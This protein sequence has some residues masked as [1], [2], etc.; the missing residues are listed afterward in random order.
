LSL[1]E[2]KRQNKIEKEAESLSQLG[3][4]F[5]ETTKIDSA[6]FY[7]NL[8][9]D[10]VNKNNYLRILADNYLILSKIEKYRGFKTSA[11]DFFEKYANIRDS[12]F[13]I[14]KFGDI[15]QLQHSYEFS[16]T[17]QQIEQLVA[18]QKD[19]EHTIYYQR[20]IQLIMLLVLIIISSLLLFIYSQKRNLSKAYSVLVD[21]N[22]E[23]IELQKKI[24]ESVREI[25]KL[26][27]EKHKNI[28]LSEESQKELLD[29]I[30][31][32]MENTS[33][34]CN[35]EFTLEKLTN[36]I[37]SN[38]KYVSF[39][40]N[41]VLKQNFSS[42][43]NGYRIREAQRLFSDSD[44]SKYTVEFVANKVGFKSRNSFSD[45]FKEITGVTPGF[46]VKSLH[47]R[48]NS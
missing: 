47:S 31:V 19:N 40:I 44:T 1:A 15:S 45:V 27:A 14:E 13:N 33:L 2:S 41:N 43:L 3:K 25:H 29:T 11:L 7:I 10:I 8:S 28:V 46:Y 23:M 18:E 32:F 37:H 4:L 36:S 21:K 6:L 12:I 5:F 30:L 24:P 34:I 22:V 42:F 17:N 39:V 20:I 38:Q 48:Q 16:K 35:S 26:S 9:N